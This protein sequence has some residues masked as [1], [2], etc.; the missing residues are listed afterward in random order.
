M[1][2]SKLGKTTKDKKTKNKKTKK[3]KTGEEWRHTWCVPFG[4]VPGGAT[5]VG[6]GPPIDRGDFPINLPSPV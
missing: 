5:E 3:K 6:G 1:I 2:R 4:V